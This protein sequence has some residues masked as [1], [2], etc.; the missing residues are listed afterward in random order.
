MRGEVGGAR[1]GGYLDNDLFLPVLGLRGEVISGMRGEDGR[2]AGR[3]LCCRVA[4]QGRVG[5]RRGV[6]GWISIDRA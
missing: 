4:W 2:V 3:G 1:K 5:G 6:A